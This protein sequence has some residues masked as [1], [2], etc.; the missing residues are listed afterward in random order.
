MKVNDFPS[1][2]T[3]FFSKH[4]SLL[5]GA[6]P[7][8]I[9]SYSDSFLLLFRFCSERIKKKPEDLTLA[10]ID[11]DL[12][13]GFCRWLEDERHC[14]AKT[15]NLRL[16]AIQSFFRFVQTQSPGHFEQCAS[17]VSV[18][19][20]A[21]VKKLP[22][23]LS[24][25]EMKLLLAQP[26]VRA[27]KGKRD[28]ALISVLFDSAMRVSELTN[29][30]TG[31]LHLSGSPATVQIVAKGGKLRQVPLCREVVAILKAYL[32]TRPPLEHDEYVFMGN[33][34]ERL[35]RPGVNYIL[36]KYVQKA[37]E[38]NP[39]LFQVHVTAHVLRHTKATLLLLNGVN[40]IYIRDL[41]GHASVTTTELYARSS[42]ELL[43]KAVE[44]NAQAFEGQ[45]RRYRK[46]Q[47][48]AL[49]EFLQSYRL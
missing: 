4:L 31:D 13:V 28:L 19:Y 40:L 46:E 39:G 2:V 29:L 21:S 3:D 32:A 48:E 44:G 43:R 24:E 26:D 12:I 23:H 41:L 20:K 34:G 22:L 47:K 35:S 16:T 36:Q 33:K 37:K 27:A 49:I 15:V 42:P 14:G 18:P 38:V 8:T 25:D 6:S 9:A 30:K 5:K 11:R 17:I 1:L 7:N 10:M 45:M